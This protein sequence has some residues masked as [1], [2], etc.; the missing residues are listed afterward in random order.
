MIS[1]RP[2]PLSRSH[3]PSQQLLAYCWVGLVRP[4][5]SP[6]T[7]LPDKENWNFTMHSNAVKMAAPH[8]PP[9]VSGLKGC[10]TLVRFPSLLSG[11]QK[12]V[13]NR[14]IHA[15]FGWAFGGG[16]DDARL[17]TC[18]LPYACAH[19]GK[20]KRC[21]RRNTQVRLYSSPHESNTERRT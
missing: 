7:R 14:R 9:L 18:D 20:H 1:V 13:T 8:A 19:D 15:D 2:F 16:V 17:S 12:A 10:D 3:F 11:F 4:H 6:A 5:L 21:K